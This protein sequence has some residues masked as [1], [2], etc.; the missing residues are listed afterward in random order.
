LSKESA[1][2]A[3]ST[4]IALSYAWGSVPDKH[5]EIFIDETSHPVRPNLYRALL[6]LRDQSK[7]ERYWID[8][9]CINQ[10]DIPEKNMQIPMMGQ[11]YSKAFFVL[12][13]LGES[14]DDS[15]FVIKCIHSKDSKSYKSARFVNGYAHLAL[16]DWFSRTWILQ[17]FSLNRA[18]PMFALG[19]NPWISWEQI[20]SAHP[21]RIGSDNKLYNR[22]LDLKTT[23]EFSVKTH[24]PLL[25]SLRQGIY[26]K[27]GNHKG[28]NFYLA[29]SFGIGHAVA[30]PRD[31]IY[32]IHALMQPG[33]RDGIIV[34]YSKDVNEVFLD[35]MTRSLI[36][37]RNPLCY[38][39]S[40]PLYPRHTSEQSSVDAV[41]TTQLPSWVLDF[42]PSLPL[43]QHTK[44]PLFDATSITPPGVVKP[45]EIVD[46]R[47]CVSG[48][49][50]GLVS[51]LIV[52]TYDVNA[53]LEAM[54]S[55]SDP[56]SLE[57]S[58]DREIWLKYTY[59][60]TRTMV[61]FLVDIMSNFSRRA[62]TNM[63]L[64][65]PLWKTLLLLEH[66]SVQFSDFNK[67]NR[68]FD[69][70]LKLGNDIAKSVPLD[71]IEHH[72]DGL[73]AVKQQVSDFLAQNGA[74]FA[75]PHQEIMTLLKRMRTETSILDTTSSLTGSTTYAHI[76]RTYVV[77]NKANPL[78]PIL[79]TGLNE[80]RCFF[81]CEKEWYGVSNPGTQEGDELVLLFPDIYMP[82]IL[83]RHGE[84]HEMI[85]LAYIPPPLR[86]K[87][88]ELG[89]EKTR[90]YTI[91]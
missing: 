81:M 17:E 67:N 51:D 54:T 64:V 90:K 42:N 66:S 63:T 80:G 82:F 69:S 24:I 31:K 85:A 32:G 44:R 9:L 61:L 40:F 86:R 70:V 49:S 60:S 76:K 8:A 88:I 5:L 57:A 23:T 26:D 74:S 41:R 84:H 83:R 68:D 45:Y 65:E 38:A 4:Y 53:Q 78:L 13:W 47:L 73:R 22:Q 11:I 77:G 72:Y 52:A 19:N 6:S 35:I 33:D 1:E 89:E 14:K 75:T 55:Y 62:A 43:K 79:R 37:I 25:Q 7:S 20:F 56:N 16:R 28:H 18:E 36:H 27:N 2:A 59:L 87:A 71:Q 12:A 91:V 34:D 15:D 29:L 3:A 30:E 50:L 58:L 10:D 48:V 46:Q 21:N 39:I